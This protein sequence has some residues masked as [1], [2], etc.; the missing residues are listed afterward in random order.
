[1]GGNQARR[2]GRPLALARPHINGQPSQPGKG[3]QPRWDGRRWSVPPASMDGWT[4]DALRKPASKA[5]QVGSINGVCSMQRATQPTPTSVRNPQLPSKFLVGETTTTCQSKH[6]L[7]LPR[8]G[9]R[10][11]QTAFPLPVIL[12]LRRLK[13]RGIMCRQP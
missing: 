10:Q 11:P 3:G 9:R 1:M 4:I 7:C 2:Q 8:H 13:S 5:K 6:L 12:L